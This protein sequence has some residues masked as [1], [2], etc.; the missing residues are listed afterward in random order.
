MLL[1]PVISLLRVC[2]CVCRG[3]RSS[4]VELDEDL[5]YSQQ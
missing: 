5:Q 1:E 2:H 4:L 3:H